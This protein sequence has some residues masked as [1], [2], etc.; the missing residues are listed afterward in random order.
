MPSFLIDVQPKAAPATSAATSSSNPPSTP[1]ASTT[2]QTPAAPAA[3]APVSST[4]TADVPAT[5]TPAPSAGA[6]SEGANFNDPSALALGARRDEAI[7]D[8]ENMGFARAEID[9]AMRAAFFNPD[10]AV[11]YLLSVSHDPHSPFT[12]ATNGPQGIP[13]HIQQEQQQPRGASRAPAATQTPAAPATG[14]TP[15]TAEGDAPINL[16]EAAAQAN[17][18]G[19]GSTGAARPG[20]AATEAARGLSNS[21]GAQEGALG[22]NLDFLRNNPQFQQLRQIVQSQPQMLE[23]ILQQVGAGNPQL[24]QLIGQNPDQFLQLLAEDTEGDTPLPPGAQ[25]ISVTEDERNAIERVSRFFLSSTH[26]LVYANIQSS[27]AFSASSAISSSRPTLRVT[28]TRSLPQTSCL[29]NQTMAMRPRV[30]ALLYEVLKIVFMEKVAWAHE[31]LSVT[32]TRT[33][34]EKG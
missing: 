1:A 18:G 11:E 31:P 19:T 5:P 7:R 26:R 9:R 32:H 16:F 22:G 3:P 34:M 20:R 25:E 28:R 14:T 27:Y 24:A 4:A 6:T 8:M 12:T 10:R 15:A 30:V 23:P 17:R 21:A 13:E 2:A 29:I 33:L